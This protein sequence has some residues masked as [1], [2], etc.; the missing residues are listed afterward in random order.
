MAASPI[1]TTVGDPG[2]NAYVTLAV[3]DQYHKDRPSDSATTWLVT[4]PDAKTAAILWATKLLDATYEWTGTVASFTQSL[5]WPRWGMFHRNDWQLI[6][7]T[8]I[9]VELQ[10]ATAEYA[11][12]LLVGDRAGDSD[13]ETQGLSSLRAGPVTL[14]FREGVTAKVVPDAVFYL[15]PPSWGYPRGR[16][17]GSR[18]LVRA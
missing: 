5:M 16:S 14:T 2:M 4:G 13:I 9:P 1:N 15:L 10:W 8:E 6:A 12:Q 11:R 18:E 17:S 3:A 7:N